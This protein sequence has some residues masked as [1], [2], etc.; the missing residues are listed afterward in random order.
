METNL[1][2]EQHLSLQPLANIH[3]LRHR[4]SHSK[5]HSKVLMASLIDK[6]IVQVVAKVLYK[7]LSFSLSYL[8]TLFESKKNTNLIIILTINIYFYFATIFSPTSVNK[9]LV[10]LLKTTF[11]HNF[12]FLSLCHSCR[13]FHYKIIPTI[14]LKILIN[15]KIK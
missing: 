9:T 7:S 1:S 5:S 8:Q 12:F 4:R 14:K 2:L 10:K 15:I 3:S 13:Y 6:V 11:H